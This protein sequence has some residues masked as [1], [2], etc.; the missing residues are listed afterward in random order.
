MPTEAPESPEPPDRRINW[1]IYILTL[2]VAGLVGGGVAPILHLP[3]HAIWFLAA[4]FLGVA[5]GFVVNRLRPGYDQAAGW[6]KSFYDFLLK[7]M[8]P[9]D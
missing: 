4:A 1:S 7:Q 6:W 2:I 3:G 9:P 5:A 8:P